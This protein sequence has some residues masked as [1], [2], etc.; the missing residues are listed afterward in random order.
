[1]DA[2]MHACMYVC[3]HVCMHVCMH[4]CVHIYMYAH[5]NVQMYEFPDHNKQGI[6][7]L[8]PFNIFC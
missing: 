2:C 5:V 3:I 7:E 1:M 4:V 8:K 6:L